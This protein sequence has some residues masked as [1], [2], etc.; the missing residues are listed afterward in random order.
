ME[1]KGSIDQIVYVK[2][3]IRKIQISGEGIMYR[4]EIP[5]ER[6]QKVIAERKEEDILFTI[7]TPKEEKEAAVHTKEKKRGRPRKA[8]VNDLM[9]K[10]KPSI[11]KAE[12]DKE[13]DNE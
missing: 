2:A 5:T 7:P 10:A 12:S 1:I 3:I 4:L 9:Q 6:D 11:D 8:T 13:S